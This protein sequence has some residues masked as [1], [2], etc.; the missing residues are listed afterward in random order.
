[1]IISQQFRTVEMIV[2]ED[3]SHPR[4]KYPRF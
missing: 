2:Q 1:M 4:F 3:S